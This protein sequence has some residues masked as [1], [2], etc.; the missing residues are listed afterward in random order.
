VEFVILRLSRQMFTADSIHFLMGLVFRCS[1]PSDNCLREQCVEWTGRPICF[2]G[3]RLGN[4]IHSVVAPSFEWLRYL[5]SMTRRFVCK[6]RYVRTL[7]VLYISCCYFSHVV[8][9]RSSSDKGKIWQHPCRRG[10][11][12]AT[13]SQPYRV[14]NH[15][16]STCS[17]LRPQ[18]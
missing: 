15:C 9:G 17:S 5:W 3:N 8:R 2:R 1:W 4:S 18:L 10:G 16:H 11:E 12:R 6:L 13:D 7:R 14:L